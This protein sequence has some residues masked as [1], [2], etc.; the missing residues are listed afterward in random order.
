MRPLISRAL[1]S[2]AVTLGAWTAVGVASANAAA[3]RPPGAMTVTRSASVLVVERRDGA[4]QACH[5]PTRR[6]TQISSRDSADLLYEDPV[7]VLVW[8]ARGRY[9]AYSAVVNRR[10]GAE[11]RVRVLDARA[12]RLVTNVEEYTGSLLPQTDIGP[13]PTDRALLAN[14]TVAWIALVPPATAGMREV[15]YKRPRDKTVTPLVASGTTI[16]SASLA[17]NNRYVYWTQDGTPRSSRLK[18]MP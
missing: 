15:R 2:A 13:P 17:L 6:V 16:E 7:R 18:P 5:L 10:D 1:L 9:V 8:G 11:V 4:T 3:C 14:G 12:R